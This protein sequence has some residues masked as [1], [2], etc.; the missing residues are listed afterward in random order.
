MMIVI[1]YVVTMALEMV[2]WSEVQAIVCL[3]KYEQLARE[4]CIGRVQDADG[5]GR[6]LPDV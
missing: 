6:I 5:I 4:I 2:W 3:G 1:C